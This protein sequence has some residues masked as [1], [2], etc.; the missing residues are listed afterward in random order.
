MGIRGDLNMGNLP[1]VD[2]R[3]SA[4][5][6]SGTLAVGDPPAICPPPGRSCP[7]GPDTPYRDV[8]GEDEAKWARGRSCHLAA[9]LP[10]AADKT[11]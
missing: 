6:D 2:G 1:A 5:I 7:P 9:M 11:T 8:L 3:L 10:T 4:V